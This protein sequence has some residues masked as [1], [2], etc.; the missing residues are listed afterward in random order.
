MLTF[1]GAI[2]ANTMRKRSKIKTARE[3]K[4]VYTYGVF[5]L[6]HSGHVELLREAK[7]LGD[8]LVVGLF[9]DEVATGFKRMPVIDFV[10]R[11]KVLESCVFTDEVISQDELL[12]DK[13]ILQ[14]KPHILAKGPGAGW[15]EQGE[16]IPG[17]DTIKSIGGKV[18]RLAYHDGI[19]TSEIIKKIKSI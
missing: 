11:K 6:F 8:R 5:D 1:K 13:N 14:I 18:V 15:D 9:T 2:E 3:K 19:S 10:N 16:K 17:E 4:V 12:P 7:K